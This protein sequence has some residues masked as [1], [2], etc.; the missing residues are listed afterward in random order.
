MTPENFSYWLKGFFE[1][2]NKEELT[3]HQVAIIKSHLSLVFEQNTI[4]PY[5]VLKDPGTLMDQ[6]GITE[7]KPDWTYMPTITCCTRDHSLPFKQTGGIVLQSDNCTI[8]C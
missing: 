3:K 5:D 2:S 4:N 6:S 8:Y 7:V 1:L